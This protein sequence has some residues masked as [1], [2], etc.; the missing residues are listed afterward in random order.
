MRDAA[1]LPH[2]A[3]VT[4]GAE[5]RRALQRLI[6]LG[7][8]LV[9]GLLWFGTLEQIS[10]ERTQAVRQAGRDAG[11]LALIFDEKV[12]RS[13]A[14]LDQVLVMLKAEFEADRRGFS[15]PILADGQSAIE[16]ELLA[17]RLADLLDLRDAGVCDRIGFDPAARVEVHSYTPGFD[18][19]VE[20]FA[21]DLATTLDG[22]TT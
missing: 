17:L 22:A 16:C 4:T 11:N 5:P 3:E 21:A 18:H 14:G 20:A 12:R 2:A 1:D 13:F 9:I 7:G 10:A 8:L 6:L 19:L 15:R